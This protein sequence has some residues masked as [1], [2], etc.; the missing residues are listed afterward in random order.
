MA[1]KAE[2]RDKCAEVLGILP[3]GQTLASQHQTKINETYDELYLIL[4]TRGLN[5]WLSS[6]DCPDEL[7]PYLS[8]LMALFLNTT[9]PMSD[10]RF[11]RVANMVGAD[12][13]KGFSMIKSLVTPEYE[14]VE[15]ATDY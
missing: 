8:N 3:V 14:S 1:T 12:G 2:L 15:E 4:K 7:N 13:E 6:G 11:A 9:Y 10:S 5:V